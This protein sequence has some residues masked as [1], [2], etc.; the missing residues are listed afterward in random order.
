MNTLKKLISKYATSGPRYT[1]YPTALY[2][3]DTT[4]KSQLVELAKTDLPASLYIHIPFAKTTDV[5]LFFISVAICFIHLP[6]VSK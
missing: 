1:S 3:S 6:D 2:F 5:A 4:D